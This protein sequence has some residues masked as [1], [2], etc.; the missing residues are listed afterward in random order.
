MSH[1]NIFFNRIPNLSVK[2]YNLIHIKFPLVNS[3]GICRSVRHSPYDQ[4][5]WLWV[6][7]G[8]SD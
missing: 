1:N 4:K 7:V 2:K 8:Y 5:L 3:K 6:F